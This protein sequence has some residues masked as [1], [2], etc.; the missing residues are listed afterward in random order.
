MPLL[1]KCHRS[2]L[3]IADFDSPCIL[4]PIDDH[5]LLRDGSKSFIAA[6]LS[7]ERLVLYIM[8]VQL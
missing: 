5:F 8:E 2:F 4:K 7:D 1:P 3:Q 6:G